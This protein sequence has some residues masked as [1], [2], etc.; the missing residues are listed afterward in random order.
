MQANSY[1][2]LENVDMKAIPANKHKQYM[3]IAEMQKKMQSILA[4]MPEK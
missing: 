1:S 4:T 2:L 3:D